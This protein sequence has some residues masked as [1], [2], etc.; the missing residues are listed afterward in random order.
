MIAKTQKV[1]F[2]SR[3]NVFGKINSQSYKNLLLKRLSCWHA[4]NLGTA[5]FFSYQ[6]RFD[7]SQLTTYKQVKV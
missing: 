1:I 5:S 3:P 2:K 7:C 6:S 4:A